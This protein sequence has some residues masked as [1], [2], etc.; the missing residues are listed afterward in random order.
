MDD[1]DLPVL[2]EAAEAVSPMQQGLSVYHH[3]IYSSARRNCEFFL[4]YAACPC[5]DD[6]TR[7]AVAATVAEMLVNEYRKELAAK[8]AA[9]DVET[10]VMF[11]HAPRGSR[12]ARLR[13]AKKEIPSALTAAQR[14]RSRAPRGRASAS[15]RYVRTPPIARFICGCFKDLE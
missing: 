4:G 7:E 5:P 12:C 6:Q 11:A 9:A 14:L 1:P 13:T 15:L 3:A 10:A 8:E 2:R